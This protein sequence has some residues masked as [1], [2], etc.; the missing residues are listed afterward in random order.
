MVVGAVVE[1]EGEVAVGTRRDWR[2][3]RMRKGR[4]RGVVRCRYAFGI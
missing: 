3:R 2:E 4:W 1:V